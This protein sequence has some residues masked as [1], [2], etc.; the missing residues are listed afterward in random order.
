MYSYSPDLVALRVLKRF[1][2]TEE[3]A[4]YQWEKLRS[5]YM[6]AEWSEEFFNNRALF[7]DYYLKQGQDVQLRQDGGFDA[8]V[9][10]P[11]WGADMVKHE[12]QLCF[13]IFST[14]S[15][16]PETYL[17]MTEQALILSNPGGYVGFVTPNTATKRLTMRCSAATRPRKH[18][19]G[20]CRYCGKYSL[21]CMLDSYVRQIKV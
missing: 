18:G 16:E 20:R 6:L 13:D 7:S 15:G 11:P 3:D 10:N 8:V 5:A 12:K 9:G 19:R 2:F 4:A 17:F 21:Y 14:K 1:T